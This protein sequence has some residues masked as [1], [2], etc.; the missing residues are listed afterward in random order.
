MTKNGWSCILCR[1]GAAA[2]GARD[3][4]FLAGGYAVDAQG[5]A[6]A[7]PDL[8]VYRPISDHWLRGAD[9]LVPVADSV[10]GVYHDRYIYL[11]GGRSM[12]GPV[13]DV[14][15]YDAEKDKWSQA[16]PLPGAPVF[17]HA[18]AL[19]DDIFVYVDGA[20]KDP[21]G[22]GFIASDECWMGK[23]DH[24]DPAKITWTKLPP[25]PGTARY[26]IAAGGSPHDQM[27]YFAG[28]TNTPYD[29]K[30]IGY[31]G[32]PAEPSPVVFAFNLRSG[33]WQ[34]IS[35]NGANPTMDQHVLVV[36]SEHLLIVG[37]MEKGQQVTAKV[38]VIPKTEKAK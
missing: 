26:R 36:V 31:D 12:R 20:A 29:Y 1:I 21:S 5:G 37:G 6:V 38:A 11:V 4:V 7:V 27:V 3:H 9:L 34:T 28:G 16:T 15:M 35:D 23:I 22:K 14:Q 17:G 13:S 24:H 2:I 8:N 33:K 19:V 10:I 32:Q 25:H 30:G 18:G